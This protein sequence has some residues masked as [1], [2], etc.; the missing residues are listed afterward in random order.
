MRSTRFQ[1]NRRN[2]V[3]ANDSKMDVSLHLTGVIYNN[4][5]H[6]TE[7]V[8]DIRFSLSICCI[9]KLRICITSL[10]PIKFDFI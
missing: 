7:N 9:V 10:K 6:E 3:I 2:G 8:H 5:K 1:R 4:K